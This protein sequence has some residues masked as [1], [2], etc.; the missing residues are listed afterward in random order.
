MQAT[1]QGINN[2][3]N[4]KRGQYLK[5]KKKLNPLT[6]PNPYITWIQFKLETRKTVN[7]FLTLNPETTKKCKQIIN[8][9]TRKKIN[10][11]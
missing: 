10:T 4:S 11:F 9:V 1:S 6:N 2:K 5:L 7:C 8:H 3:P